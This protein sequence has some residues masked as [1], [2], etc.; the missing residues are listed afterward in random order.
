M[1]G[2]G[3]LEVWIVVWGIIGV[4]MESASGQRTRCNTCLSVS[5][6]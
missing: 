6:R 1:D 4:R 3:L 5:G 2:F